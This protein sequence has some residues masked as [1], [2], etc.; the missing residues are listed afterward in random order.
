MKIL[1]IIAALLFLLSVSGPVLADLS[2]TDPMY[3]SSRSLLADASRFV[4]KTSLNCSKI[5][6][7]VTSWCGYC[8]MMER[9]L[10]RKG[11]PYTAYDIEKDD[12]AAQAYRKLGGR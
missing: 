10:T 11:V 1:R 12:N 2:P 5:E 7:F 8:K 6:I 3:S 9:F 4:G